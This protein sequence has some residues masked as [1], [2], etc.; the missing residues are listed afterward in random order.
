MNWLL[1]QTVLRKVSAIVLLFCT[2]ELRTR[3]YINSSVFEANDD[4]AE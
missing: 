1:N 3:K 4:Y 2:T